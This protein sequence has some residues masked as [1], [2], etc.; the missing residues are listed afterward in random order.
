MQLVWV[1]PMAF[2]HSALV[3]FHAVEHR[4][5]YVD[6]IKG[7][8]YYNDSKGTNPD[9]SIKAIQAMK[10][11]TILIGGGYDKQEGF[12]EWVEA[13]D[14]RVKYL[15]LLGQT[16]KLM[17]ETAKKHGFHNIIIVNNLQEAVRISAGKAASGDAVL[18]SPACASWGMFEN[19]EQRGRLFKKYV[20]ELL[21]NGERQKIQVRSVNMAKTVE[22]SIKEGYTAIMITAYYFL[23]SFLFALVWL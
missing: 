13:F 6:T 9:A 19:Y 10:S 16:S 17:A 20:R 11:P 15:I 4:I 23:F 12:D 1:F 22:K 5:E 7:V 3:N 18:L 8:A 21:C 2:I 14:N